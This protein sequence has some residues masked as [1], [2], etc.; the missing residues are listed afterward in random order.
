MKTFNSLFNYN[1]KKKSV[2]TLGTFDGVHIGHQKIL[3]KLV[4][5]AISDDYESVLLT[6]FPHPR[7]VL[8]QDSKI[9]LLNTIT[10]KTKLIQEIGVD[11]LI[12]HPF[13]TTFSELSAE[14]FVKK[15]LVDQLNL[16]KII[17]GYDHKFGK[18]R[19]ADI[20]DLIS[21]GKKYDF[22]VEQISAKEID[23]ISISSTKIRNALLEGNIEL[24]NTYLGNNY[25]LCGKVI[26]GKKIGRT[27]GYPTA[28]LKIKEDYKL[29]PKNGVYIVSSIIDEKTVF[30]MMNIGKNPTVN[31][32]SNSIEIHFFDFNGEI[33]S[34]E[35]CINLLSRIRDE[36]KFESL[37]KLKK[38]LHLDE[39]YS[40]NYISKNDN[41]QY[42]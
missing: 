11:N 9:Q 14:D 5:E 3:K 35:I 25:S 42:L 19:S 33:Y 2:L 10:E 21:L 30:G 15:I 17:I 32:E 26:E 12:I 22:E 31:G 28:N 24:A 8:K 27:I 34:K 6:F 41:F 13:D 37:D 1:R 4:K 16:A 20:N 18:N 38:Q 29:I 23:D 39:I 7:M 36:Q 40:K